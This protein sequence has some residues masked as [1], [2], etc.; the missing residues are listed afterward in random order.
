MSQILV[1]PRDYR[2]MRNLGTLY[3]ELG[4]RAMRALLNDSFAMAVADLMA[5]QMRRR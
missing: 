5:W 1:H 3:L 4:E 2:R